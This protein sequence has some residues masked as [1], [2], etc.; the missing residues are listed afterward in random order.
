MSRRLVSD[1]RCLRVTRPSAL[2]TNASAQGCRRTGEGS[3]QARRRAAKAKP[4]AASQLP[5]LIDRE[6]FFGDPEIA[7][8]QISPDGRYIAFLKPFK[9]TRNI[10]VKATPEP[11]DAARPLT[12]DTKRPISQYF[13]SRDAKFILFV[14]DQGG[15]ENYNVYAVN[16][17]RQAGR[18]RRR[19]HRSQPHGRQGRARGH[20][21]RA[22]ERPGR[23]ST[24]AS[25]IAT[26]PGTTSTRSGSR[27]ASARSSRRTPSGSPART[28]T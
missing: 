28:S 14:Q 12:A 10:W 11:F 5:V 9:G 1:A 2:A 22:E 21:R 16:P 17:G 8:A 19:P 27:P 15:D 13:W 26:R 23:A 4:A 18:R 24:S 3:G 6:Q 7:G 20:L 25:T